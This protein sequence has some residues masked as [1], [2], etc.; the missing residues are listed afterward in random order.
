[1]STSTFSIV[2]AAHRSVV[3]VA[4]M[5]AIRAP[6]T[7]GTSYENK[8]DLSVDKK[9]ND[10]ALV[11]RRNNNKGRTCENQQRQNFALQSLA[12]LWQVPDNDRFFQ[13]NDSFANP[14]AN[15]QPPPRCQALAQGISSPFR[16]GGRIRSLLQH[17]N[18]WDSDPQHYITLS[19]LATLPAVPALSVKT[20]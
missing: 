3:A 17:V 16:S 9:S 20:I 13:A 5:K 18:H 11:L 10:T 14:D 8:K 19:A 7:S 6:K 4:W 1:M 12:W 15:L 2:R